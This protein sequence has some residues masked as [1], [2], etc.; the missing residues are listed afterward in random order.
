MDLTRARRTCWLERKKVEFI[1]IQ[2]KN[3]ENPLLM[4]IQSILPMVLSVSLTIILDLSI[5]NRTFSSDESQNLN[6]RL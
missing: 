6:S 4:Q 3:G 5:S 2:F 1:P